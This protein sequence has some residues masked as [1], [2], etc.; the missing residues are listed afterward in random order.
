MKIA[1]GSSSDKIFVGTKK[2]IWLIA[3][4]GPS[5][6]ARDPTIEPKWAEALGYLVSNVMV[7]L[8]VR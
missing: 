1:N 8:R 5:R 6:E 7:P 3:N 2:Y 4:D